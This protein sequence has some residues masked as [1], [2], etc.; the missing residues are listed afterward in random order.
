MPNA[1]D[2]LKPATRFT[3]FAGAMW[4]VVVSSA[5]GVPGPQRHQADDPALDDPFGTPVEEV[6]PAK[7]PPATA[8]TKP[9]DPLYKRAQQL[10]ADDAPHDALRLLDEAVKQNPTARNFIARAQARRA[11]DAASGDRSSVVDALKWLAA[12]QG[13]HGAW[14]LD[15]EDRRRERA[16][17]AGRTHHR[18][19]RATSL[20]LLAFLA[21]GQTHKNGEYQQTV[22]RGLRFLVTQM[23]SVEEVVDARGPG[24]EMADHA[25]A[26][27]AVCSCRGMTADREL[28]DLAQQMVNFLVVH[29]N[30]KTGGWGRQPGKLDDSETTGW[31]TLA[32]VAGWRAFCDIPLK[33]FERVNHYLDAHQ[34]GEAAFYGSKAPGKEPRATAHALL[35]R[36]WTGTPAADPSLKRGIRYLTDWGLSKYDPAH[37]F[38]TTMLMFHA[39]ES[40]WKT[41]SQAMRDHLVTTQIRE[42][43][44]AGSWYTPPPRGTRAPGRLEQTVLSTV[45]VAVYYRHLPL[46]LKEHSIGRDAADKP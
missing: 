25:L 17:R 21:A 19:Q 31:A 4:L 3:V 33:T 28:K 10:L 36:F 8:S 7:K 20:A 24:G 41:W 27:L 11:A 18:R 29:Q 2:R 37:N 39:D 14:D 42:G 44:N 35:F 15:V 23:K 32:V 12:R 38:F 1:F 45:T 46:F 40:A 22:T 9:V 16:A 13:P 5:A 43:S 34:T 6:S 26:T 30:D